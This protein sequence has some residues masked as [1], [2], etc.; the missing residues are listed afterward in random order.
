MNRDGDVEQ[1]QAPAYDSAEAEVAANYNRGFESSADALD[2]YPP[3]K[4]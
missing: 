4:L 3:I 1:F 2:D